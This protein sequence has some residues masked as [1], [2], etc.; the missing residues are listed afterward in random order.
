MASKQLKSPMKQHSNQVTVK[1]LVQS[2]NTAQ[3]YIL[4][5]RANTHTHAC[6]VNEHGT[7]YCSADTA[8]VTASVL[9]RRRI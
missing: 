6:T 8:P 9:C 4:P 3:F 7:L 5:H 1:C 2:R